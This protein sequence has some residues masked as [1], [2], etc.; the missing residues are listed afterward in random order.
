M[1][2]VDETR[3]LDNLR[4]RVA[5]LEAAEVNRQ[6]VELA[7]KTAED[8]LSVALEGAELGLWDQN[9]VTGE[10]VRSRGWTEMLGYEQEEIDSSRDAWKSLIHPDDRPVI[11]KAVKDHEG[12]RV[13]RFRVEH[14]MRTKSGDWKWI[15][16][17][18]RV[19]ERASDNSPI[20]AAGIHLDI[21]ERRRLQDLEARAQRLETAG[22][23][24]GQV[25]HD[26]SNLLAPLVA[27]PDLIREEIAAGRS[28]DHFL[29][30]IEESATQMA[31]I[32]QQLLALGRR[33][34][35]AQETL[36]L[37]DVVARLADTIEPPPPSL[38]ISTNLCNNILNIKGGA[39]QISR[40]IMN[41]IVNSRDATNDVGHIEIRT[42]NVYVD[43][44]SFNYGRIQ[45]GEYVRLS[46]SDSGCG[47]P[48]SALPNIFDPFFTTKPAGRTRGSGLGLSV[49]DAVVRDHGGT[50]DLKTREGEG[51]TI[52]VYFPVV[53]EPL[54]AT[55]LED[56]GGGT[57]SILVV[58]DDGMQREVCLD[59]LKRLGYNAR[60]AESG[61]EALSLLAG[62]SFDM[63][64]LD[65]I[66]P[67]GIDG[68]ETYERALEI[69]P[70]QRAIILSGFSESTRAE[71]A[72][73][74][75]AGAFV[76][77][78][79]TRKQLAFNVRRELDRV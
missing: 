51:T 52:Y 37:N 67:P 40:M 73:E 2:R 42:K 5:E 68:A 36:N 60:A 58:D 79:L 72:L 71:R 78:P 33:G 54:N 74:L 6:P 34:H 75:G 18:G 65:M 53:R 47:I 19:I 27:Y 4:R 62:E 8:Q 56:I 17:W 50:I 32:S 24:A 15:L 21:T 66:M 61:E 30:I 57:E 25:A 31:D 3:E 29:N 14:R 77:K 69:N 48:D 55:V 12:G 46:V 38:V 41:L 9:F 44:L 39:A 43:D 11:D 70:G 1:S 49:V 23:V 16:N 76:R 45:R 28:A 7:L 63:L 26:F 10:I 59:L 22:R 64:I 13:K 20:R 35:Y